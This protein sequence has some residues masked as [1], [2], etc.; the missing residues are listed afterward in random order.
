MRAIDVSQWQGD[1]NWAAVQS[2]IA[3]I[4]MSGGDAG[5]YYD[6]KASY[7]Y[8]SAKAA[9]KAIGM[10]HFAG[11]TDATS[12]A[13]FFIRACSPLEK[14]DVLILD[15]EVRHAD[16]VG[17]CQSFIQRVID[18]TGVR[19]IIY[20]N[21]STENSYDWSPVINQNIGLWVADYRFGPEAN[22]PIKYWKQ[23][24]MHQYTSSGTEPGVAGRVDVNEWFSDAATFR[25]YGYQT[26]VIDDVQP[27]PQP[28]PT[29]QPEPTPTPTPEP[30]PEAPTTPTEPAT[31]PVV[32][33]PT[34]ESVNYKALL[35]RAA[36]TFVG[37][38]ASV[39]VT[40][41]TDIT[42]IA[43]LKTTAIAAIATAFITVKN[44]VKKPQEAK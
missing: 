29:P 31:P 13:D 24:I 9:G 25:K 27:A 39:F 2:P 38:F 20:M 22:V 1:I 14:D 30:A 21:T 10:Y 42:N 4:K 8:Q 43:A 41:V 35:V 11:G 5:T 23:Y 33:E 19:P 34:K 7:N 3:L 28:T 18:K 44:L 40:N 37:T 12:E 6:S 16:P 36:W 15:W 26:P 32:S 17:W